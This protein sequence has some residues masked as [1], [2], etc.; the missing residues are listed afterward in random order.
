MVKSGANLE[1]QPACEFN[2]NIAI[3]TFFRNKSFAIGK[4]MKPGEPSDPAATL[5]YQNDQSSRPPP[6][7]KN[8]GRAVCDEKYMSIRQPSLT[9]AIHSMLLET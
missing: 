9:V 8:R 2:V 4:H 7:V 3:K 6:K 5:R 1:Q